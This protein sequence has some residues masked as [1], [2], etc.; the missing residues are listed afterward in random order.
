MPRRKK[1]WFDPFKKKPAKRGDVDFQPQIERRLDSLE[2]EKRKAL[3]MEADD[4]QASLPEFAKAVLT[5]L[6]WAT[7]KQRVQIGYLVE[8]YNRGATLTQ[9]LWL[10][11]EVLG[12]PIAKGTLY[13]RMQE[14]MVPGERMRGKHGS[15]EKPLTTERAIKELYV[16]V[17][18]EPAI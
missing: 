6:Q 15:I 1:H 5:E 8:M 4:A 14:H 10:M 2:P 13:R 7:L 3:L 18:E 9:L 17:R 16:E 11:N 12:L